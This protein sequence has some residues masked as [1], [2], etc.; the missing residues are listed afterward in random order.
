MV[1]HAWRHFIHLA[2]IMGALQEIV[3]YRTAKSKAK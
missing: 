3:P 1:A 2:A